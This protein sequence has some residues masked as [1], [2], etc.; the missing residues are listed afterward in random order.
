MDTIQDLATKLIALGHGFP[1]VTMNMK[2]LPAPVIFDTSNQEYIESIFFIGFLPLILLLLLMV[3]LMVYY[4]VIRFSN[5]DKVPK[6]TCC[7]VNICCYTTSGMFIFGLSLLGL[8]GSLLLCKPA[9]DE[10]AISIEK[11]D[12][13]NYEQKIN[14]A[15][16]TFSTIKIQLNENKAAIESELK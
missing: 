15:P 6:K 3:A 4:C 11:L 16:N 13:Q 1:H 8:A 12:P 9:F 2:L 10:M 7:S 5:E 14:A